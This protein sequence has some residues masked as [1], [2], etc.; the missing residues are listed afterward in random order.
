LLAG[1]PFPAAA[2]DFRIDQEKRTDLILVRAPVTAHHKLE[3]DDGF[4]FRTPIVARNFSGSS[5]RFHANE[6]GL[7][8]GVDYLARLDGGTTL[9]LRVAPVTPLPRAA[10]SCVMLR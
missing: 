7:I 3:I 4:A 1:L 8:P 10:A 5:L 9:H 6:V 2:L